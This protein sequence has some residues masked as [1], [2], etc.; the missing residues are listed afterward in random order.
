MSKLATTAYARLL[1]EI[2]ARVREAQYAALRAVNKELVALYW[3]I[4][5]SIVERQAGKTWGTAIVERL[6]HDL[7]AE[8]PGV[9]GF[10]VSNL[11]RMKGVFEAYASSEKL[12]PLVREVGWSHNL[13]I[14][15]R[16]TDPLEREFYLRVFS[17]AL[18]GFQQIEPSF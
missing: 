7:H 2:K 3:D 1:A 13:I 18:Q 8:F 11:W 9:G 10:S 15:E 16:C 4:G 6:A 17:G 14:L 5:R 12:A